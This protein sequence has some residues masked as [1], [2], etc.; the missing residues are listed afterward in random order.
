MAEARGLGERMNE[1]EP[2]GFSA[3]SSALDLPRGADGR[4]VSCL[5]LRQAG[6]EYPALVSYHLSSAATH[7]AAS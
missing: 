7:G 2:R 1:H 4:A 3:T 6:I 5:E